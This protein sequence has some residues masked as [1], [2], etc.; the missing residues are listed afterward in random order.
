MSNGDKSF[1][2]DSSLDN[3]GKIAPRKYFGADVQIRF[4]H[5]WGATEFRSEY[6]SGKQP[7]TEFTTTNPGTL[8]GVPTYIRTFN[9]AFFYF[10]KT[11]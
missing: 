8:P 10:C 3:V 4:F 2:P 1:L 6:W 9:G 7:G 5:Q 11:S